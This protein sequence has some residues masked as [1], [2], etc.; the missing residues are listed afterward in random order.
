MP[1]IAGAPGRL[2]LARCVEDL[3]CR[4]DDFAAGCSV[5]LVFK[6]MV[7]DGDEFKLVSLILFW[8]SLLGRRHVASNR[9]ESAAWKWQSGGCGCRSRCSFGRIPQAGFSQRCH[10]FHALVVKRFAVTKQ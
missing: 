6:L 5:R 4:L 3:R 8:F 2:R 7:R 10:E 9:N 1:A